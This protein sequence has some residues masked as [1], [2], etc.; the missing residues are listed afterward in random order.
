M[1]L[2]LW[3]LMLLED[4]PLHYRR[5]PRDTAVVSEVVKYLAES[6]DGG[7]LLPSGGILTPRGLQIL[8]LA[9]LIAADGWDAAAPPPAGLA[10]AV[11]S[12]G[13]PAAGWEAA[14]AAAGWE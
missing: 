4:T 2:D 9:A 11:P 7:V 13:I 6:E 12:A 1:V 3:W 14:P 10:A 5:F 8:G